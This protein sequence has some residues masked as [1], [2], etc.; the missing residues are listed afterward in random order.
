MYSYTPFCVTFDIYTDPFT[1]RGYALTNY[2]FEE[3]NA[4]EWIRE[5]IPENYKIYSDPSTVIEMRGLSNRPHIEGI[6]W[7]TT[8]AY[9]VK[10]VCFLRMQHM[11]IKVS[12]QI[13][14]ITPQ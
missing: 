8:T 14:V 7:N 12:Y 10:C 9:E 5:N 11:P 1:S 3:F 6:G 2:T 4:S 13:T